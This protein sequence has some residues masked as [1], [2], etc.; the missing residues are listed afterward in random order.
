MIT[1][2]QFD[3]L[4][5]IDYQQG[6]VVSRTIIDHPIGTVTVF[7]F[8]K[9]QGLSEHTAP[10][11]ALVHII[12][13][14]AMISIAGKKHQ[15]AAPKAILMPANHPHALLALTPYKMVLTMIRAK[16]ER[17]ETIEP[18]CTFA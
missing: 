12:D 9:G 4:S 8:D 14:I 11:D 2:Q 16:K 10:Y 1:G 3:Y 7:A 18:K 6:S 5:L 15:L 13:G 17:A